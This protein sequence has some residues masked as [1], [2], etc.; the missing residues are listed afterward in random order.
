MLF[1][2]LVWS[3]PICHQPFLGIPLS[4]ERAILSNNPWRPPSQYLWLAVHHVHLEADFCLKDLLLRLLHCGAELLDVGLQLFRGVHVQLYQGLVKLIHLAVL[5]KLLQ[6]EQSQPILRDA[7]R[8]NHARE[9]EK[10]LRSWTDRK[11]GGRGL[12]EPAPPHSLPHEASH[13]GPPPQPPLGSHAS[14]SQH[15]L[16]RQHSSMRTDVRNV[17]FWEGQR[18]ESC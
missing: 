12:P 18:W 13:R 8:G 17:S 2:T 6:A 3:Q 7:H 10:E 11:N 16:S 15:H 9:G 5:Q 4:S 1:A 14:P